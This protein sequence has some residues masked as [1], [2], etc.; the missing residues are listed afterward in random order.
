M[1][2]SYFAD[3]NGIMRS[4]APGVFRRVRETAA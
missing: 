4:V 2:H 3:F 1:L